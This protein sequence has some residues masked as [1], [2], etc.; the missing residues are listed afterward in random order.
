MSGTCLHEP[1]APSPS[2]SGFSTPISE[3]AYRCI[4]ADTPAC[5][6]ETDL[7]PTQ[8]V[9][10]NVLS[11]D[12]GGQVGDGGS[13]D[14][15]VPAHT[16]GCSPTASDGPSGGHFDNSVLKLHEHEACQCGGS[17]GGGGGGGGGAEAGLS[18]EAGAVRGG[19]A[20]N[21]RLQSGSAGGFL[22]GLFG[23]LK[24]VWTMIGK[25]YSTEHKH[26]QEGR[27]SETEMVPVHRSAHRIC[28]SPQ[29]GSRLFLDCF[30]V[31]FCCLST[32]LVILII[33]WRFCSATK[34]NRTNNF[35]L[36]RY[37]DQNPFNLDAKPIF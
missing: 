15:G 14:S 32:R 28:C 27:W 35:Q 8:C 37:I 16:C 3:S 7:T 26:H 4:D 13:G 10:R 25:A 19:Q 18:S 33:H 23:C 34:K 29:I 5:T 21:T 11:I 31:L 9:L 24:P 12:T 17:G 20:D 6:P 36:R 30:F 22:E 1:R 2:L